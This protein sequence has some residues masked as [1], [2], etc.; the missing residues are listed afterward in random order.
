VTSR[1]Q[2]CQNDYS[3]EQVQRLTGV[4]KRQLQYWDE[5]MCLIPARRGHSR[6]YSAEQV[7][8]VRRLVLLR[9]AGVFRLHDAKRLLDLLW[10]TARK[11]ERPTVIGDVLVVPGGRRR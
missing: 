6:I 5:S 11:I 9:R 1:P 10:E 8:Q 3:S 2:K 7:E 4:S